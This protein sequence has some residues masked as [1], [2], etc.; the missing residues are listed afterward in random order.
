MDCLE[1][2]VKRCLLASLI[3]L[4]YS[5]SAQNLQ[6]SN[7]IFGNNIWLNFS[8]KNLNV[9][10]STFLGILD[11]RSPSCIS[12]G[13]GNILFYGS[14]KNLY[15]A[16]QQKLNTGIAPHIR[17]ERSMI[18]KIP[19]SSRYL[20]FFTTSGPT[21]LLGSVYSLIFDANRNAGIG[22]VIPGSLK[23]LPG[24]YMHHSLACLDHSNNQDKWLLLVDSTE[25]IT[26]FLI[27]SSGLQ[28]ALVKSRYI[29]HL[30]QRPPA[31]SIR[32]LKS[33]PNSQWLAI[34]TANDGALG[35]Y[36]FNRT[37]GTVSDTLFTSLKTIQAHNYCSFSPNSRFLYATSRNYVYQYDLNASSSQKIRQ[38]ETIIDSISGGAP[39]HYDLQIGIDGKIY[40]LINQAPYLSVIECPNGKG[41][42]CGYK[43]SAVYLRNNRLN[44]NLF[45]TQNQTLYVNAHKLQAQSTSA[46][47]T[48]CPGDSAQ[49]VA[50]GASMDQFFWSP[51]NGLS[52]TNCPAPMAAPSKTTTYRVIGRATSCTIDQ[53]DTA[54]V[55]VYV[56]PPTGEMS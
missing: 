37:N 5:T 33:S 23:P 46:S 56:V 22:D 39:M 47:D 35:V 20:Y 4:C 10:T 28:T 50:Y 9:D 11:G 2:S 30:F 34:S 21:P 17:V 55:T 41:V 1:I 51:G 38:S 42:L 12:D 29:S 49:L 18:V 14:G 36:K 45:P 32:A 3:F 13:N 19:N 15:N 8:V 53:L 52:C 31:R 24:T 48:L 26:T 16:S 40:N 7:W 44:M 6:G 27:D 54:F 43:D 25:Q